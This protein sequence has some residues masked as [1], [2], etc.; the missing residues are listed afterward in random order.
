MSDEVK[1]EQAPPVPQLTGYNL[2]QRMCLAM[3]AIGGVGKH[4][5][6][7][8]QHYKYQTAADIFEAVQQAF[9]KYGI[10]F[11]A[12]EKAIK[13]LEPLTTGKGGTMYRCEATMTFR[14]MNSEDREIKDGNGYPYEYLETDST[15]IGFDMSDK[16]LNKAKTQALKYFL[17][18][19]FV[20]G[21]D[22]DDSDGDQ[23]SPGDEGDRKGPTPCPACGTVGAIIVGKPEFGGG[24]LCFRRKGG[25]GAKFSMDPATVKKEPEAKAIPPSQSDDTA[26]A[27]PQSPEDVPY[28]PDGRQAA[29]SPAPE[30]QPASAGDS[31]QAAAPSELTNQEIDWIEDT[32]KASN[33]ILSTLLAQAKAK[34]IKDI[35]RVVFEGLVRPTLETRLKKAQANKKK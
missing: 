3:G 34:E 15:G 12:K 24:W 13:W 6:N 18:P 10:A 5:T 7:I 19:T 11:L 29:P 25:C 32:A 16:A 20:I 35:S 21:E 30:A 26:Q 17:K 23:T 2:R 8:D 31:A 22:E 27:F 33:T 1:N 28:D 4:G 14:L 9:A